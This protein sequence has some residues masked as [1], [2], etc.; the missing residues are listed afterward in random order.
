MEA[1]EA[2]WDTIYQTK[3]SGQ[4]SWTEADPA[5]SL[6]LIAQVCPSG[7]RVLDVGGGTSLLADRLL[8]RGYTVAVLD[9]SAEALNRSRQRLGAQADE[10][11]WLVAD[12]TAVADVGRHDVWHDRA[13]FHFLTAAADRNRYA[14]LMARSVVPGGH[15]IVATFALDGP[16]KC[17]GLEVC[18]YDG[19]GLAAEIGSDFERLQTIGVNHVTPWGKAQSFQ[20]SLF[21]RA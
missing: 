17:S 7:G 19:H 10:V 16:E 18:R 12:V 21:R 14:D 9:V 5:M 13:V 8:E 4:L 15:A 6:E 11:Q 20:Y 2:H 1:R 3:E